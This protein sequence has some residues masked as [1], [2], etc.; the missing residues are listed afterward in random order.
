MNVV[1]NQ[2]AIC[3]DNSGDNS[4]DD[5]ADKLDGDLLPLL[6]VDGLG[7]LGNVLTLRVAIAMVSEAAS[8]SVFESQLPMVEL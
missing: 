6:P 5:S 4:D 2:A 7:R 3:A 1:P 8:G